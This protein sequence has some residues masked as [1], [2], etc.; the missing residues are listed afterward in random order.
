MAV[1]GITR[2]PSNLRWTIS[3]FAQ[4]VAHRSPSEPSRSN[5]IATNPW[6]WS[7]Y[8]W[9]ILYGSKIFILNVVA[10]TENFSAC[11]GLSPACCTHSRAQHRRGMNERG[12]GERGEGGE[13]ERNEFVLLLF[14]CPVVPYSA[15]QKVFCPLNHCSSGEGEKCSFE[16]IYGTKA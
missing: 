12:E 4:T 16:Q 5:L 10:I 11:G 7:S 9:N 8:N 1:A 14:S 13:G 15:T 6:F 3:H 2:K